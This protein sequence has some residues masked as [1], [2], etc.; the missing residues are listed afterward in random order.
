MARLN[1]ED[2][3]AFHKELETF[4]DSVSEMKAAE[5]EEDNVVDFSA[6][7]RRSA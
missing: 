6:M 7:R 3:D 5:A 2:V 1:L 4:R